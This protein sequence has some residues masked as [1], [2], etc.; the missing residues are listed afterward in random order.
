MQFNVEFIK[1]SDTTAN[2]VNEYSERLKT[3]YNDPYNDGLTIPKTNAYVELALSKSR[4]N[5]ETSLTNSLTKEMLTTPLLTLNDI[6]KPREDGTPVRCVLIDGA[7]GVGKST[8]AWEVCHKWA[9]NGLDSV[10]Q[11]EL[12]VLVKLREAQNACNIKDLFTQ[13]D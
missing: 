1:N 13:L 12:V 8:L 6:L 9:Q 5:P 2:S 7:P 3:L 10:K 4:K 11:F